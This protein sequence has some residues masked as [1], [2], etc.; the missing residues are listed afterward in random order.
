M[1]LDV[2]VRET[3]GD[4]LTARR[5]HH[6]LYGQHLIGELWQDKTIVE[7]HI[8]GTRV[9]VVDNRGIREVSGF[10]T[11]AVAARAIEAVE[12]AKERMRAMVT[13]IG[14]SVVV[15]RIDTKPLPL[16]DLITSGALTEDL[17]SQVGSAL[18]HMDAVTV[19]GPAARVVIRA[20]ASL[21]PPE[22][23]V[24]EG[25]YGILPDGCVAAASPLDADYVI[26]VRPGVP[27][28]PMAAAGQVGAL[29]ANPETDFRAAVRLVVSGRI[30]SIRK[31][32]RVQD[33]F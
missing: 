18:E 25:S 9:L 24:F 5:V 29:I 13:R 6:V 8:R 11:A 4:E 31:V 17:A 15:S 27:A 20:F 33:P 3:G 2:L 16:S 23:R 26:G 19:I 14:D 22:S 1:W 30:S 7:V 12:A 32:T 21:I 28:E 10:P